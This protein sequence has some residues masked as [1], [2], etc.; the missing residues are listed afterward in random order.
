MALTI[1]H[2]KREE[3]HREAKARAFW[4]Q[5]LAPKWDAKAREEADKMF[6][7]DKTKKS[8]TSPPGRA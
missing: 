4:E 3:I 1:A 2:I 8:S 7:K 6:S 5:V